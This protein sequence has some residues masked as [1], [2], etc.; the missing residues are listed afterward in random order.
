[1][2]LIT[3]A[4]LRA[5]LS[6]GIPNPYLALQGDIFT[7]AA[8]DFLKGRGISVEY[9]ANHLSEQSGNRSELTTPVG[10][11]NRHVH[12][13][14][15]DVEKLFGSGYVLT[16]ERALSQPGQYAAKEKL[17]LLGPKGIIQG[18][19][20]LG[21]ARTESQVEISRT[22]GY[23]LGVHPPVRLSGSLEGTP[24]ITLIGPAGFVTLSRG[25]IVAKCHVHMSLQE[26]AQF[27]VADGDRLILQTMGERPIIYPDV[28]VRTSPSYRLDFHIDL[29][30]ANAANLRSGDMVRVIGKQEASER[31]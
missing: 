15:A 5:M 1:M 21:P 8:I 25:V 10:V 17:T 9:R 29:D 18:V 26:A 4:K 6:K 7:P 22:D 19:R 11:S 2:T 13:S 24:G 28:I 30:E 14:P 16:A 3:E 27:Q 12:L 23:Q 20:I 31:R